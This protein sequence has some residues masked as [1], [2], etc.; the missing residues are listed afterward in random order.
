MVQAALKIRSVGALGV[1]L[2]Q[3]YYRRNRLSKTKPL[4]QKMEPEGF[5]NDQIETKGSQILGLGGWGC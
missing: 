5:K 1:E 2:W 4:Q 3:F